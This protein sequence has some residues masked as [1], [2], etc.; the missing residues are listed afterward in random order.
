[1]DKQIKEIKEVIELP[2]KHPEVRARPAWAR[3]A[4]RVFHGVRARG[5]EAPDP[6]PGRACTPQGAGSAG[7][8]AGPS[9]ALS[10]TEGRLLPCGGYRRRGLEPRRGSVHAQLTSS[11]ALSPLVKMLGRRP[12]IF[13]SLGIAQP[14]GVLL[15]GP[16][17][18]ELLKRTGLGRREVLGLGFAIRASGLRPPPQ[19][20]GWTCLVTLLFP[21]THVGRVLH[22][23]SCL[24]QS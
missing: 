18:A 21:A 19:G 9:A 23:W 7:C 3:G 5:G 6:R 16:P 24:L 20:G 15:Y 2:I 17:G 11:D 1:M 13:E 10:A 14:K 4:R 8:R 22:T 12:Q